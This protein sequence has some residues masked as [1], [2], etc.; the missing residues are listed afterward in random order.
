[1]DDFVVVTGGVETGPM[2]LLAPLP[3]LSVATSPEASQ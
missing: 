2:R 1:V 3:S